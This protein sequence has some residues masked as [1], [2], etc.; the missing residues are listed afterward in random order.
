[1]TNGDLKKQL[2]KYPDDMLVFIEDEAYGFHDLDVHDC[3]AHV[4]HDG[5]AAEPITDES[6]SAR[7]IIV[8]HQ[9]VFEKPRP[10]G[11]R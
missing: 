11:T 8:L 3:S 4:T 6:K 5:S 7:P 10:V 1:M 9:R 2:A